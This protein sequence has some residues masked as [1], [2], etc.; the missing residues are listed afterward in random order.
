[1]KPIVLILMLLTFGW[2]LGAEEKPDVF[3]AENLD[4]WCIVPFDALAFARETLLC[5]ALTP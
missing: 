5:S 3:R 4:A 2:P 1:M